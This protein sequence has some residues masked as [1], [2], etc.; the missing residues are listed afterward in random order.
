MERNGNKGIRK[1]ER[2]EYA[3]LTVL[4][5]KTIQFF[6]ITKKPALKEKVDLYD[7]PSPRSK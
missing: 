7:D 3:Q 6:G 2:S 5:K 1:R 4:I